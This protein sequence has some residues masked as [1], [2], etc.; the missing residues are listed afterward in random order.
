MQWPKQVLFSQY[1]KKKQKV[2]T[3]LLA[4]LILGMTYGHLF[5]SHKCFFPLKLESEYLLPLSESLLYFSCMCGSPIPLT[6][7]D[8]IVIYHMTFRN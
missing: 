3:K 4:I 1:V 6:I 8:Y 2:S 7:W 5:K